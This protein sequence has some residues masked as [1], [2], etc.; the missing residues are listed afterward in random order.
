MDTHVCVIFN[1]RAGK[2]QAGA[3]LEKLRG[4][5]GPAAEFRPTAAPGHAEELAR[6]AALDGF[7]TVAAAGGDGTVHEVANGLLTAGNPDVIFAVWPMGS[8]ND[9]AYAL[10]LSGDPRQATEIRSVDV[11][12]V[13]ALGGHLRL[14]SPVGVVTRILAEIPS[15]SHS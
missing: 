5:L 7:A 2:G 12:R 1:P 13:E 9:Y 6:K 10:S 11:G 4:H 14:E 15:E 3:S 8:A